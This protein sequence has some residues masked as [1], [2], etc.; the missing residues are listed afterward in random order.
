MAGFLAHVDALGALAGEPQNP[1]THQVIH[2]QHV[3]LADQAGG[4]Q[5]QQFGVAGPR[6]HQCHPAACALIGSAEGGGLEPAGATPD[7]L[8]EKGAQSPDGA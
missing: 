5:G 2:H 3:G 1:L 7:E 6:S 4:A 8:I